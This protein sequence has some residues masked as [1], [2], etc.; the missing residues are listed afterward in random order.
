MRMHH[1]ARKRLRDQYER[2]FRSHVNLWNRAQPRSFKHVSIIRHGVREL[3]YDNLVGGC[4]L[5]L[6]A[7]SRA[8]LIWD[9]SGRYVHVEYAQQK[10]SKSN[11]K[12]LIAVA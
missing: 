12:T 3:D 9:D 2:I 11:T 5:L 6:D 10:V 1:H 4:K 7:L 8:G